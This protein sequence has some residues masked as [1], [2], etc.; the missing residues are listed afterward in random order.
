MPYPDATHDDYEMVADW[1]IA[2]I[3]VPAIRNFDCPNPQCNQVWSVQPIR[4]NY[5]WHYR[6]KCKECGTTWSNL[7][8]IK[9]RCP[10][11]GKENLVHEK[12][13][14]G[15]CSSCKKE[16]ALPQPPDHKRD[17]LFE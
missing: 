4:L 14:F 10:R 16:G 1:E 17:D 7:Y 3:V 11:C 13:K 5:N 6:G 12:N 9:T 2:N 8:R 15:A